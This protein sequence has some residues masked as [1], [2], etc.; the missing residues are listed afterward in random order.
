[1]I[2]EPRAAQRLTIHRM[3]DSS[4]HL[5]ALKMGLGKTAST[6]T[7]IDELMHDRFEISKVLIVAPLRVAQLVWH[8]EVAKWDHLHQLRVSRVLGDARARSDALIADANIFVINRE[9][10]V[11][12]VALCESTG[13]KWPFDCVVCDENTGLKD[14]SSKTWQ[15]LKRIR[16]AVE[17][18]YILSGTPDSHGDL[19]PLWA[20]IS[21]LDGGKR[22]GTSI[23]K[24]RDRWYLPDKRN[25]QT[26]FT[27]KLK[28]GARE[29]IQGLVKDVML[30]VE[31][32]VQMPE[33]IDNVIRVAFDRKRYDEMEATQ[34]SG[35]V[36]AVNPAVLAG[37]LGQMSNGA[38]FDS[39]RVV[40]HIHDAKLDALEEV[41]E[42]GEPVLCFTAYTHDEQRILQR[43]PQAV[44]F[45]GE[46]SL[47]A[48]QEGRIKLLLMHPA[49]AGFGVDGLQ[50]GGSVAVWFGLPFALDL[51]EQANARIH[52]PGQ[53][54]T[55]VIHHL[56]AIGTIDEKIMRVLETKGDMQAALLEAVKEITG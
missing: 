48:W 54:G 40:H 11:W 29:E 38:V 47:R 26:I 51:Y 21:L 33:R 34:V 49:S 27:W 4:H 53:R 8:T 43:F 1:M 25:A 45:D 18:F 31:G 46:K 22:L 23:T 42:Q 12:L 20:Q 19:M 52:R 10:L 3:L 13:H 41:V 50:L 24:Y 36:M 56:V 28:P 2:F 15:A 7:A 37:K 9:N 39:N 30:N 14:R 6:L 16:K 17:R 55:V 5:V 35:Q 44:K 32:D